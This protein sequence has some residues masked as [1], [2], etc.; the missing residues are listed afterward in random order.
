MDDPD[1][2]GHMLLHLLL[3]LLE[4]FHALVDPVLGFPLRALLGKLEDIRVVAALKLVDDGLGEA[5]GFVVAFIAVFEAFE[6]DLL[7]EADFD[8][9]DVIHANFQTQ[10]PRLKLLELNLNLV[11]RLRRLLL[12]PVHLLLN[13]I[14]L[15]LD[16]LVDFQVEPHHL[17]ARLFLPLLLLP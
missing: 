2:K 5:F 17:P 1:H 16:H 14:L 11:Y 6:L 4:I 8:V 3:A 13:N 9:G 15:P 12:Q 10:L 7:A